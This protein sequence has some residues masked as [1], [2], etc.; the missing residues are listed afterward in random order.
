MKL[1]SINIKNF[2]CF[3]ERGVNI[4][5]TDSI[6]TFIGGNSVGKSTVFKAILRVLSTNP[7][8]RIFEHEDFFESSL[9]INI[10]LLIQIPDCSLSDDCIFYSETTGYIYVNVNSIRFSTNSEIITN[11]TYYKDFDK[12]DSY[13]I[14][15]EGC[16]LEDSLRSSDYSKIDYEG[17]NLRRV[18][19]VFYI[20]THRN[21]IKDIKVSDELLSTLI[22]N[23]IN[24]SMTDG[25]K[26]TLS[27]K[28]KKGSEGINDVLNNSISIAGVKNKLSLI[29]NEV[30]SNSVVD[31]QFI[32]KI[33][34]E[35]LGNMQLML[36]DK[37]ID[38]AGDGERSILAITMIAAFLKFYTN[39][40]LKEGKCVLLM[41]EEPENHVSPQ[42][43]GR[44]IV[45]MKDISNISNVQVVFTTHSPSVIKRIDPLAIRIFQRKQAVKGFLEGTFDDK[46]VRGAIQ[47]YPELYF[48]K[49]V[50]LVEGDSEEKVL[51]YF[52]QKENLDPDLFNISIV[53]L[54]G[55]HVNHMWRLM[56]ELKCEYI[57]LLDLDLGKETGGITRIKDILKSIIEYKFTLLSY[58]DKKAKINRISNKIEKYGR[59]K[60]ERYKGT[61]EARYKRIKRAR[62]KGAQE[63]H[64]GIT[65]KSYT[66]E[67]VKRCRSMKAKRYRSNEAKRR[68]NSYYIKEAMLDLLKEL[69]RY[70]VYF[71]FPLDLDFTMLE[72]F[73]LVYKET[74][75]GG[76]PNLSSQL[77]SQ[78][79]I[80]KILSLQD[81][82]KPFYSRKQRELVNWYNYLFLSKTGKPARHSMALDLIKDNRLPYPIN[83][84]INR[85]RSINYKAR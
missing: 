29:W 76:G 31:F 53:P 28:I 84:L 67:E 11:Y 80:N 55:R 75:E 77:I 63:R 38:Q 56:E 26:K 64:R 52:L 81:E 1:K 44:I 21:S 10:D 20:P 74:A 15:R 27:A 40:L 36:G 34:S 78:K 66:G 16:L 5:F 50:I 14:D 73:Q 45:V 72:A 22:L 41:I 58:R 2:G 70:N 62:Y 7:R 85:V 42:L 13:T 83:K 61:K 37:Y 12:K 57:T 51:P 33:L 25:E 9:E 32:P 8:D 71:N 6:T 68:I 60:G 65:V 17:V 54:G 79:V 24:N 3:D 4:D 30:N 49:L 23:F 39:S 18:V 69:E 47:K 46:Y 19:E 82:T 48:S 35:I 43:L 59:I